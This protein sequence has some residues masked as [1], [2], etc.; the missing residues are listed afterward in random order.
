MCFSAKVRYLLDIRMLHTII[1]FRLLP[2]HNLV[3]L[4]IMPNRSLRTRRYR[5]RL[6]PRTY[7]PY[8]ANTI[9]AYSS[10]TLPG[11]LTSWPQSEPAH[12]AATSESPPVLLNAW[13]CMVVTVTGD[14]ASTMPFTWSP[15]LMAPYSL[16]VIVKY[17]CG[18]NGSYSGCS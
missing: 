11:D 7:Y 9:L 6:Q 13:L 1:C 17:Y 14:I 12:T 18:A 2:N 3:R 8:Q 4:T 10:F 16:Y 15:M 5:P